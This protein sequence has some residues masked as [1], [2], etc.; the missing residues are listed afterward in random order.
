MKISKWL[1]VFLAIMI[2]IA[3][4]VITAPAQRAGFQAAGITPPPS[5][6]PAPVAP[7]VTAPVAPFT[8]AP[9]APFVSAPVG[10]SG[11]VLETFRAVPQPV[12]FPP[13]QTVQRGHRGIGFRQPASN[14]IIVNVPPAYPQTNFVPSTFVPTVAPLPITVPPIPSTISGIA[15]GMTR[16]QVISQLGQPSVTIV[17]SSGETLY[18]NGGATVIIQNGQVV[19]GSR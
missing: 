6:S 19:T 15:A 16:G 1:L 4:M 8:T 10:P 3:A 11:R 13:V 7:F 9:V 5:Q 18:F 2:A 14:T 12:Y 17:T